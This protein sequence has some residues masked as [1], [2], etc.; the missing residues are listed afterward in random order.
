[1]VRLCVHVQMLSLGSHV[2]P[3]VLPQAAAH[4]AAS[5]VLHVHSGV[6]VCD[7]THFCPSGQVVVSSGSLHATA[8]A[9]PKGQLTRPWKWFTRQMRVEHWN[10]RDSMFSS[11][12]LKPGNCVLYSSSGVH[13][14]PTPPLWQAIGTTPS[15]P[16]LIRASRPH[17][18][19]RVIESCSFG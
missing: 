5:P 19:E 2:R 6:S 18:M 16:T 13:G 11:C 9:W 17:R 3:L 12:T 8:G 10:E 1:M 4:P 14:S 7:S 15:A